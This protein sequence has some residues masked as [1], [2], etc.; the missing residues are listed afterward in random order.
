MGLAPRRLRLD[1]ALY[2]ASR[3]NS[4][5][6]LD[7]P[8][9]IAAIAAVF[10]CAGIVKGIIGFALPTVGIGLLGIFLPPAQAASLVTIPT[11]ATTCGS[12]RLAPASAPFCVAYGLWEP[13]YA[14]APGSELAFSWEPARSKRQLHSVPSCARTDASGLLHRSSTFLRAQSL[15]SHPSLA[16]LLAF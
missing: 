1:K 9:F 8:M 6:A 5:F 7:S 2:S 4:P 10:V 12:L 11:I 3:M 13:V 15:G 14:L 16:W